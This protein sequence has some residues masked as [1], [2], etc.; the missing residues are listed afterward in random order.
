[1]T[2]TPTIRVNAEMACVQ[3]PCKRILRESFFNIVAAEIFALFE[4]LSFE[5][6]EGFDVFASPPTGRTR[7]H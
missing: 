3:R 7:D 4:H 5:F 2:S 6:L 1:M